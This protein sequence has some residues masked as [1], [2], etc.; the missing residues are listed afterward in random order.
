MS[1]LSIHNKLY[2]AAYLLGHLAVG[3]RLLALFH[4]R[5]LLLLV[6]ELV[7]DL[8]HVRVRL[9]HLGKVVHGALV[10]DVL[11]LEA[12]LGQT[13]AG[14]RLVVER[15]LALQIVMHAHGVQRHHTHV[16]RLDP[17]ER[18]LTLVPL[19]HDGL[20]RLAVVHALGLGQRV[21]LGLQLLLD[22]LALDLGLLL[23][24]QVLVLAVA[25]IALRLAEAA[26]RRRLEDLLLGLLFRAHERAQSAAALLPA[27]VAASRVCW[28]LAWP[29]EQLFLRWLAGRQR[30]TNGHN[31]LM[32]DNL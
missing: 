11:A 6:D 2:K 31:S 28:R 15:H 26:K 9:E 17:L 12:L 29:D 19:G 13:H 21:L 3:L 10:R 5:D 24:V 22:Q 16:Q 32:M 20:E 23:G 7:L 1:L 4:G 18:G 8:G 25:V 30:Y 14:Q 27:H